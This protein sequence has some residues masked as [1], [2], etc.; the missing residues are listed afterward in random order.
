MKFTEST[1]SPEIHHRLARLQKEQR[2][3]RE[4]REGGEG[5]GRGEGRGGR[6]KGRGEGEGR[7]R[8]GRGVVVE[9]WDSQ[10]KI[11]C[12]GEE[13]TGRMAYN[14]DCLLEN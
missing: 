2:G 7:E 1:N 4:R 14:I 9:L 13:E 5:R 10:W 8:G 12:R 11:F 3:D 6:G